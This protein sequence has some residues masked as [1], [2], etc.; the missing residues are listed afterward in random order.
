[1]S[2]DAHKIDALFAAA[3]RL[4]RLTSLAVYHRG[5]LVRQAFQNGLADENAL[6]NVKSIAKSILSILVGIA[7]DR[8]RLRIDDRVAKYLPEAFRK[9]TG[10][11]DLTVRQLLTMT[12]PLASASGPGWAELVASPD[13]IAHLTGK[14]PSANHGKFR[15][16]TGDTHVLSVLLTHAAD[17][18]TLDFAQEQLFGPLGIEEVRWETDPQGYYRGGNDMHLSTRALGRLGALMLNEGVHAGKRVVAPGWVRA[19]TRKQVDVSDAEADPEGKLALSGYGYLWWT[20]SLGGDPAYL[21]WGHGRQYLIVVP[22]RRAVVTLTS[23]LDGS[24]PPSHHQGVVALIDNE[25][26]AL[27]RSA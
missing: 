12:G 10:L 21:G 25:L 18:S 24:P 8:K 27:L 6:T 9:E 3:A 17:M 5:A 15:Y 23:V 4:E 26:A 7:V 11:Y 22:R 19:S 16:S 20:L 1:M 2:L 14:G 13:W